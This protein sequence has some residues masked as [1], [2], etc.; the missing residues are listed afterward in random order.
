ML[1]GQRFGQ[2]PAADG[3]LAAAGDSGA[4]VAPFAGA[5]AGAGGAAGAPDISNMTPTQRAVALYNLVMSMH[6]RGSDSALTFAPMA[7]QAY[8][9]IDSLSL[10][11]RYDMG[12]IAAIG[13]NEPLARAQADTILAANPNHLLGLILAANAAHMRHDTAAERKFQQRL[14]AAAPSERSKP[15]PEYTAHANDITISLDQARGR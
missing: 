14:V 10:D 4:P 1:A 7:V 5:A 15:L 6:E 13:G 3:S 12:R 11:D 8:Q 2:R 9:M